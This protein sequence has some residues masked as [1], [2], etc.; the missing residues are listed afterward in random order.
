VDA[1]WLAEAIGRARIK[2]G[3]PHEEIIALAVSA[4]E[5]WNRGNRGLLA[6]IRGVDAQHSDA[7][8]YYRMTVEVKD[9]S[10]DSE[11]EEATGYFVTYDVVA[12]TIAEAL[13]FVQR[14]EDPS[15]HDNLVVHEHQ[16][17]QDHPKEL[18]GV[19]SRIGK[20]YYGNED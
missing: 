9:P 11:H 13:Q 14:L 8:L 2:L 15:V 6:L 17:F 12:D 16:S 19:Y 10:A 18:K 7:A 1:A 4:L 3:V 20:V 5:T